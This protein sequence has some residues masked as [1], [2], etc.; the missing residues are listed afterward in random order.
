MINARLVDL[1]QKGAAANHLGHGVTIAVQLQHAGA[2]P[3]EEFHTLR[4]ALHAALLNC[5]MERRFIF[6]VDPLVP[7]RPDGDPVPQEREHGFVREGAGSV[8]QRGSPVIHCLHG[9]AGP[10]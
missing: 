3:H 5:P 4:C 2:P 7:K 10:R 8:V 9:D 6:S 1:I